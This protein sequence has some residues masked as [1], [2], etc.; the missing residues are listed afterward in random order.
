MLLFDLVGTQYVDFVKP[1]VN[2][3]TEAAR[4]KEAI[5]FLVIKY[6]TFYISFSI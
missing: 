6:N 2:Q 3:E 1:F 5:E 4:Q